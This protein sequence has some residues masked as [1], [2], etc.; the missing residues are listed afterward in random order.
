MAYGRTGRSRLKLRATSV[1][2]PNRGCCERRKYRRSIIAD[3]DRF[4]GQGVWYW[5]SPI[6][7]RLCLGQEII[8]VGGGNSAGQAAVFLSDHASKIRLML[9]G[10]DLSGMSQYLADRVAATSN[11]EVIPHTEIVALSGARRRPSARS[12]EGRTFGNRK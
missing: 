4:E 9:R 7:A 8:L 10:P 5:A 1:S 12:M 11:I 6:E 2:N 3:L